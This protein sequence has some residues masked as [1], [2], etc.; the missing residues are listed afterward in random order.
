MEEHPAEE[1]SHMSTFDNLLEGFQLI[2]FDWEYLYVNKALLKQS[3][4]EKK[5]E[6]IGFTMMEKYPG[7]ENTEMFKIL[8]LC[9]QNRRGAMM[10]NEFTFPDNS[11]GWF[12]LRIEPVPEGLFILSID[13]TERKKMEKNKERYING[14]EEMLFMTSH[15]V[16]QPVANILGVSGLLE[17]NLLSRPEIDEMVNYIKQSAMSLDLFTKELTGFIHDLKIRN[18]AR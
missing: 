11:I 1:K 13:V 4:Y 2:S 16:R 9:M 12:E 8:E 10:E 5:E 14:L 17:N 3:K 18:E 15:K 6:L 7:I